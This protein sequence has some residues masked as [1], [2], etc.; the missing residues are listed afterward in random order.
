MEN[1]SKKIK[2][3][4]KSFAEFKKAMSLVFFL[5]KVKIIVRWYKFNY[6]FIYLF[7][8][9]QYCILCYLIFKELKALKHSCTRNIY[10]I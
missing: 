9:F 4:C 10:S 5:K 3:L 7:L 6:I 1:G 8:I 2:D